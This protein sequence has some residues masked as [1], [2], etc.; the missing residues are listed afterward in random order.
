MNK[1]YKG[2]VIETEYN[3]NAQCEPPELGT[4]VT[5]LPQSDLDIDYEENFGK[6]KFKWD[7]CF[8]C[9]EMTKLPLVI[10]KKIV[11]LMRLAGSQLKVD[12]E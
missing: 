11:A 8:M 1:G 12:F 6:Q 9:R 4:I 5:V 10:Q 7:S 3:F 2:L